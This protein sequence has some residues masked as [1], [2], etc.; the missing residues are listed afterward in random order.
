MKTKFTP[1]PWSVEKCSHG[2]GILKRG[3]GPDRQTRHPQSSLQ[4]V[5]IE[6]ARLIASAPE[7]LEA[8]VD[9]VAQVNDNCWIVDELNA[10]TAAIA[11]AT[12][13]PT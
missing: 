4:I 6:D 8:L 1:G 7:L 9:L 2:G 11:K 12:G 10:A 5:P 13:E 3:D